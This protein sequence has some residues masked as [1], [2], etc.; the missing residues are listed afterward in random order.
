MVN[1]NKEI[2]DEVSEWP[3]RFLCAI[4]LAGAVRSTARGAL[5]RALVAT[6]W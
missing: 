3:P 2:R 1:P 5:L 4:A 6:E